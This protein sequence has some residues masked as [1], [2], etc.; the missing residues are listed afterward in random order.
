MPIVSLQKF[1]ISAFASL[2]FLSFHKRHT[3][4]YLDNCNVGT[5][6][7]SWSTGINDEGGCIVVTLS[8]IE[9][10]VKNYF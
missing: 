9:L 3:F 7:A 6:Y 1:N 5:L 4:K 10:K 8:Q 2:V